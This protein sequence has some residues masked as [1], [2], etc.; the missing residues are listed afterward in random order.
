MTVDMPEHNSTTETKYY[1]I[2]HVGAEPDQRY[3][4]TIG[5]QLILH[6]P[7]AVKGAAPT[8]GQSDQWFKWHSYTAACHWLARWKP[9]GTYRVMY[10]KEDE[11]GD[12]DTFEWAPLP[13]E[14]NNFDERDW[15][16]FHHMNGRST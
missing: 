13:V 10:V 6:D 7:W 12:A 5:R 1:V 8:F 9:A 2:E 16:E 4:K 3:L 14:P 15:Q 11:D